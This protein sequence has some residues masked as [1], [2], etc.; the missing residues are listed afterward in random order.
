VGGGGAGVLS[1]ISMSAVALFFGAS[2]SDS[3]DTFPLPWC[4]SLILGQLWKDLFARFPK[5]TLKN[6]P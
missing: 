6:F 4:R 5:N 1:I 2:R 3:V